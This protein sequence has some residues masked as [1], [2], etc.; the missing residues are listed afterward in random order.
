[1]EKLTPCGGCLRHV[2]ASEA[3]CPFCGASP[4]AAGSSA[5]PSVP[6]RRLARA[7]AVASAA[8][9]AGCSAPSGTVFYGAAQLQDGGNSSSMST[10]SAT[11]SSSSTPSIGVFYGIAVS[12]TVMIEDA[13]T[14]AS[15]RDASG[16][17]LAQDATADASTD[18]REGD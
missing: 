4:V 17:A 12:S 16:D 8:T 7:A 10:S 18:A 1:M 15:A 11:A 2:K 9:L 6:F 14:D 13:G 3:A 5:A